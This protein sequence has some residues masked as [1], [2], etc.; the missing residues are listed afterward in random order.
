[1]NDTMLDTPSTS[2]AERP[3]RPAPLRW[4]LL[5]QYILVGLVLGFQGVLWNDVKRAL[6]LSE[7]VFG[8]AMLI[9]PLVGFSVL[10][11][12]GQSLSR[13][14]KRGV[15]M[16]GL[17]TVLIALLTL[18]LAPNLAVF[19][20]ARALSG[21]GFG[22]W[23]SAAN[24]AGLD[25]EDATGRRVMGLLFAAFSG[26]T[27]LG[28]L[29]AGALLSVGL[30]YSQTILTFLP[31]FVLTI[32][33][34]RFVAY[35]P[36]R[37]VSGE[38]VELVRGTPLRNRQFLVLAAISLAGVSGEAVAD[39]WSVIYVRALGADALI[40]SAAFALFNAAMIAG[41]LA[42]SVLIER[43]GI[44]RA[45][46]AATICVA[47]AAALLVFGSVFGSVAAFGL[48]GLGVAGVVPTVLSATR[49]VLPTS[50]S[51]ATSS[52]IATTYLGFVVAPPIVG[53]IADLLGLQIALLVVLAAIVAAMF[54][55]SRGIA[56]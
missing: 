5:G 47:L 56:R 13:F 30:S 12:G 55:L 18:A 34:T 2:I 1:M 32:I 21:L 40:G 28:A 36:E 46:E 43:L 24:N 8:T 23:D 38:A 4:L 49:Q 25:W 22:L 31:W 35:A 50:S 14:S 53:W 41:R 54:A 42:N 10:F 3:W 39:L 26:G 19:L 33:V 37:Y 45:F 17:I 51:A 48:L 6:A 44:R 16:A 7:G 20:V 27:V 52:I 11:F 9:T 29:V 15:S